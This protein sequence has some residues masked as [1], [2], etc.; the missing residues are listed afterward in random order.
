MQISKQESIRS[1]TIKLVTIPLN[2]N[3]SSALN[4]STLEKNSSAD[5][6]MV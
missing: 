3:S 2:N 4:N 1:T 6:S 5:D